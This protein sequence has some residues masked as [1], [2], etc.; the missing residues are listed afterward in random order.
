MG[1]GVNP[2]D[3]VTVT[4][5]SPETLTDVIA[6]LEQS[7]QFEHLVYREAELDA[8][9]STSGF[10]LRYESDPRRREELTRLNQAALE[11]HDLIAARR[12]REA[13]EAL[14]HFLSS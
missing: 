13:A 2:S 3:I 11:A 10:F 12:P 1:D 6:H 4:D 7:T 9:W 5:F 8:I 14:R